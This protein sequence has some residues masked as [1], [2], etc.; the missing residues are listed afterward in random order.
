[1]LNLNKEPELALDM[2][3]ASKI[4]ENV[5]EESEVEPNT[6]PLEV[7]TS[8]SSYRKE[9]FALQRTIL[10]IIMALFLLLPLLFISP[11]F[12]LTTL[13]EEGYTST[14]A[15]EVIVDT[16][17]PVSRITATIDGRNIPVYEVDAHKYSIEPSV[18]GQMKVTVTLVNR[19]QVTHYITVGNVDVEAPVIVSNDSDGE[20]VYL[21]LSDTGS[22]I[23]FKEI[24]AIDTKGNTVKPV[25]CD[26]SNGRI[27]FTYPED[28]LN[29]YV[30][31]YAGN[32]LQLVLS[33]KK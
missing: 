4:L 30:T 7:L 28:S 14:P 11:T 32:T 6:I 23:N 18:N 12:T 15:Y 13:N 21:N 8:Y 22:G 3:V 1:M 24:K 16:F 19:Q 26:E 29:V 31:D 33:I 2:E 5:F 27:G 10:I 25:Y 9:R 20:N 17:M